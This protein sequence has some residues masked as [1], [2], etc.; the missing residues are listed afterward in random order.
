MEEAAG[1]VSRPIQRDALHSLIGHFRTAPLGV[2]F[3]TISGKPRIIQ[4]HSFPR[5]SDDVHSQILA[6]EFPCDWFSFHDCYRLVASAPPRTQAAVFDVD[7]AFRRIP[8]A[9]EDHPFLCILLEDG[10]IRVDH[11]CCFA[12]ASCPGIFGCIADAIVTIFYSEGIEALLKWVDDFVFFRY[13]H[14]DSATGSEYYQY[15]AA[16]IWKI[17]EKLGWPWAAAKCIDFSTVFPYVGFVWDMVSL[18]A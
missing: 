15:D 4:D 17:G 7:A 11:V 9:P 3:R 12:C 14:A 13:T 18:S 16:F 8:L 10:T 6:S 1:R 5:L 2:H